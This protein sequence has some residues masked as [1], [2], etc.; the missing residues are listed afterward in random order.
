MYFSTTSGKPLAAADQFWRAAAVAGLAGAV[1]R[2]K[3]SGDVGER[4]KSSRGAP[5]PRNWFAAPRPCVHTE[6]SAPSTARKRSLPRGFRSYGVVVRVECVALCCCAVA[7]HGFSP[8]CDSI[9]SFF[10]GYPVS[11]GG[12]NF[13]SVDGIRLRASGCAPSS[14]ESTILMSTYKS[15]A[16]SMC[17]CSPGCASLPPHPSLRIRMRTELVGVDDNDDCR[18]VPSKSRCLC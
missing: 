7:E 15:P 11:A 2:C 13:D 12:S 16:I 4:V 17:L 8:M 6:V 18:R 3:K 14:S 5:F 9:V 10:N 1:H